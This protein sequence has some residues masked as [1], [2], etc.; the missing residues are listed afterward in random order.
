MDILHKTIQALSKKEIISYKI[1]TNRTKDVGIRKDVT[2][3]DLIKK[4]NN[5][6]ATKTEAI[7]NLY[8]Q[9]SSVNTYNKLKNRLLEEIDNSLV[10]FYFHETD[11]HFIH[12]EL[13]LFHTFSLKQ[14]WQVAYYH[15]QKAEKK[16]LQT[17][18][19]LLLEIIYS[20]FV[21]LCTYYGKE[22]PQVYIAKRNQNQ[23]KVQEIRHLD[24]ALTTIVY[25]LT[26]KQTFGK[27][28]TTSVAK[29][30]NAIKQVEQ[31]KEF[32]NNI[33][34]KSK[35]YHAISQILISKKDFT[36]LES[37][38][39]KTYQEFLKKN[40]FTK[41]NHDIKLLQLRYICNSLSW[42]KKHHEALHYCAT[43]YKA[44]CEHK[45][46][47]HD[48]NVFFY[49]NALANNYS[50]LNTQKAIDVLTEAK[51]IAVIANHPSYLGYV[52]LNLAGAY[53]DLKQPK[54]AIKEIIKIYH[55]PVFE[56]LNQ[57]FKIQILMIDVLLR[58][59]CKQVDFAEKQ[60]ENILK[61]YPKLYNEFISLNDKNDINILR[62]FLTK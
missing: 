7:A 60:L 48:A 30:N 51:G 14:E 53:F 22:S 42:N 9:T 56:R 11:V 4:T 40:Y 12:S 21:K 44:M 57:S 34:F 31:K 41:S 8:S 3:F 27:A 19:F 54:L 15:L 58:I 55:H 49:Y 37:Y 28:N 38:S 33:L 36:T 24:D 59:E 1:Y 17:N 61:E 23:E 47:L 62:M 50:V 26:K 29:L 25:E 43:Y 46:L 39:I 10:Q 2:L 16:A 6:N 45:N 13:H 32:K 52:Y 18:S 20:E 5:K 35:L